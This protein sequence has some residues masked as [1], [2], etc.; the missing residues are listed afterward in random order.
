MYVNN[1]GDN[2]DDDND[3]ND[4]CGALITSHTLTRGERDPCT[5]PIFLYRPTGEAGSVFDAA[6]TFLGE[7]RTRT[8]T[9]RPAGV[10]IFFIVADVTNERNFGW[11]FRFFFSSGPRFPLI[12]T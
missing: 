2:D 6:H 11:N 9:P 12:D 4:D 1:D 7:Y 3:D 8:H 10:G 5:L